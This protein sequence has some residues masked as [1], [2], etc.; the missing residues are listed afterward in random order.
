MTATLRS[1]LRSAALNPEVSAKIDSIDLT[2]AKQRLMDP[3][4]GKGW[5]AEK[6]D[7]VE[8]R[9]KNFLKLIATGMTCVPTLDVDYL[10]H[11]HILRT[12]K[13]AE[14]CKRCF[15]KFIHHDPDMKSDDLKKHWEATNQS[16]QDAFGET[17]SKG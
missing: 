14:D 4:L 6:A 1:E 5:T 8:K 11:E 13:Y 16:Y 12:K 10:W 2:Q 15:G 7:A 3:K 17:Y 9:Y